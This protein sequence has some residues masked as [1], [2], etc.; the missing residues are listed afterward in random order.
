MQFVHGQTLEDMDGMYFV[1]MEKH[2]G[3]ARSALHLDE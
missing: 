3:D 2:K 1:H